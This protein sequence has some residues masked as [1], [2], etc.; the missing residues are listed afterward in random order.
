MVGITMNINLEVIDA[1]AT[2][3][4]AIGAFAAAIIALVLGTSSNNIT[5]ES[6]NITRESN[7]ET[8]ESNKIMLRE[9]I[10]HVTMGKWWC[11]FAEYQKIPYNNLSDTEKRIIDETLNGSDVVGFRGNDY[12]LFNL[13][14]Q[15]NE[16]AENH[17][18]LSPFKFRIDI[19]KPVEKFGVVTAYSIVNG[20]DIFPKSNISKN[21]ILFEF[22]LYGNQ[23]TKLTVRLAYF[24]S[25]V[26]P[27]SINSKELDNRKSKKP[28]GTEVYWEDGSTPEVVRAH[29]NFRDS[30]YFYRTTLD[31]GTQ[32]YHIQ[33]ITFIDDKLNYDNTK[34]AS[35]EEAEETFARLLDNAVNAQ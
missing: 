32:Y 8:Q 22:P 7:K 6:N 18:L 20:K 31:D 2:A 1:I 28:D 33:Q 16:H 4:T 19:D 27:V 17:L 23:R 30:A 26:F 11:D 34:F 25:N 21:G 10:P 14:E 3:A 13:V 9:Y 12:M 24:C 15:V 29:V 35:R 5:R